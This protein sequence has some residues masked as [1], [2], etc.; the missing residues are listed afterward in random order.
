MMLTRGFIATISK[1]SERCRN[2]ADAEMRRDCR[3]KDGTIDKEEEDDEDG[4]TAFVLVMQLL[5][6][7]RHLISFVTYFSAKLA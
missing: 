2:K 7:S 6:T 3:W 5:S 1:S 4:K